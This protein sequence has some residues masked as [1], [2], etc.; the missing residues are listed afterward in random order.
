MR[1]VACALFATLAACAIACGPD[2][3]EKPKA[4][5]CPPPPEPELQSVVVGTIGKM[6]LV[7]SRYALSRLGDVF[8]AFKPDLVLVGVRV[9]PFRQGR[10]EDASFEMTYAAHL[11]K[12]RGVSVEPIDWFREDDLAAPPAALEPFDV[13]EIERRE[14]ELLRAP[15]LYTFEQANG[16]ELGEKVLLAIGAAARHRGG[17]PLPTRRRAWVQHLAADAVRRHGKPKRVLAFVDVLDRPAVDLVLRGVG[18]DGK[19]PV[20]VIANAKEVLAAGD[21]PGEVLDDYRAQLTRARESADKASGAE[22]AFWEERAR[23]LG[24]VVD[25]KAGCCVTQSALSPN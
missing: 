6:H 11:A 21:V 22:K 18:Y 17:D 1:F 9:D 2:A 23:V 15:R 13:A 3:H 7:E 10:L 16:A 14:A 4:P 24:V 25:K 20:D 8:A 5:P 12:S 19:T